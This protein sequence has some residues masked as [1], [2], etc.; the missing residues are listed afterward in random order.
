MKRCLAIWLAL[1]CMLVCTAQAANAQDDFLALDGLNFDST[2][3]DFQ[4]RF[5]KCDLSY[6]GSLGT[7]GFGKVK[8][9]GMDQDAEL[10][11][12][13][14]NGKPWFVTTIAE[15]PAY[16]I[17]FGIISSPG[18]AAFLKL[19]ERGDALYG[20]RGEVLAG[21]AESMLRLFESDTYATPIQGGAVGAMRSMIE[22][23]MGYYGVTD[24]SCLYNA[25]LWMFDDSKC[26]CIIDL[27]LSES[28]NKRV[29]ATFCCS[30]KAMLEASSGGADAGVDRIIAIPGGLEWGSSRASA[31]A[32]VADRVIMSDGDY[33]AYYIPGE[34]M[35]DGI[36]RT[37][38]MLFE[39]DRLRLVSI[40]AEDVDGAIYE[41]TCEALDAIDDLTRMDDSTAV[42]IAG[43]FSDDVERATLW[44]SLSMDCIICYSS[45]DDHTC[46]VIRVSLNSLI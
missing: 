31:A 29:I 7:A 20:Q 45:G 18:G 16:E 35:F 14:Q 5:G 3:D 28:D 36:R 15:Y 30:E 25:R 6:D 41:A 33:I 9:D 1:M 43:F 10:L 11:V 13:T 22:N 40:W 19:A 4:S 2:L 21:D 24:T 39:E 12:L 23:I 34:E 37:G 8:V 27:M 42:S 44:Y 38:M 17:K 32:E 46:H 26:A